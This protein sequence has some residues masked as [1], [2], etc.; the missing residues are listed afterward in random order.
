AA[1]GTSGYRGLAGMRQ[2][3]ALAQT[4]VKAAV[5]AY[6]KI[7]ADSSVGSA[8]QDLA[9]VRAGALLIDSGAFSDARLAL[10]PLSAEQ[11]PHRHAARELLAVA[12]W[13]SGDMTAARRWFDLIIPDVQTPPA[14]RDRIEMLIALVAAESKG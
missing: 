12:A 14:T 10:E 3:A 8:L 9:G 13:R 2:A 11:R 5:A 6:Q 4:D 7:A 1:E